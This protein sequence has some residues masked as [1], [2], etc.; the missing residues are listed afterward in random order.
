[1]ITVIKPGLLTTVQ[2]L[3]RTGYQQYGMVVAGAMDSYSLQVGNLLVGNRRGE[4]GLEIT[5]LGPVLR[6]EEEAVIALTGADLS[7]LL[8]G[9]PVPL[10]KSI[11]IGKGQELRFKGPVAGMRT[12]LCVAG[13]IRVPTVMGSRSTYLKGRIG[14]VHGRA[15]Q[16]G[17]VLETG[18]SPQPAD[19]VGRQPAPSMR[20]RYGKDIRLRVIPGPQAEAFTEE[21]IHTFYHADFEVTSRSDR[22]GYRLDGPVIGH[23][24]GAD[25][26]SDAIAPGAVQIP[27]EGRPI[28][29]MADR[30]T[31]G[32]YTKIA[33]VISV[34]LPRLAQAGPGTRIT[35][36][37]VG[38]DEA[39]ELA[40]EQ[41]SL[42]KILELGI[43]SK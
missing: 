29:L 42:L 23:R 34:D 2:D 32:G 22:M 38:V 15:L 39:Q 12:Y 11:S 13:G 36:H 8:D 3:G 28:I 14:G 9:K 6:F 19:R 18:R 16:S 27:A 24:A 5:W 43:R 33:T 40:V 10:W 35:F 41:E 30:Q 7:P 4:A 21:G 37:E 17:D 20:P 1:M 26:I 31:T 25:I